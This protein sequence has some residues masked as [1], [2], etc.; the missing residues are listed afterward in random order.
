MK[1][2]DQSYMQT[3]LLATKSLRIWSPEEIGF[4]CKPTSIFSLLL[5]SIIHEVESGDQ[6]AIIHLMIAAYG[7]LEKD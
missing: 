6:T 3:D 1:I 2:P 7:G 5:I 4:S